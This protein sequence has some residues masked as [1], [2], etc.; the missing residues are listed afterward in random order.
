MAWLRKAP[1]AVV[2][3]VIIMCGVIALGVLGAFVALSLA[4]QDTT[5]L[6]QWV[7]TIGVTILVPL[8]GINTIASVSGANS[9]A[10][11]EDQTNGIHAAKDVQIAV[12]DKQIAQLTEQLRD[13]RGDSIR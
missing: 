13:A 10:A 6:R 8:L 5:D 4:G 9:A 3:T 7:Q 1:T 11:A 2:V 12:R